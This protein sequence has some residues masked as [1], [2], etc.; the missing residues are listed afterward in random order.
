MPARPAFNTICDDYATRW[1][2]A[3]VGDRLRGD[4]EFVVTK[5]RKNKSR[6]E[7]MASR[8]GV[9][10]HVIGI[11]HAMEAGLSFEK[12]LH[13]GDPLSART[14]QV[15]RARPKTGNPPFTWEESAYDALTH[16]EQ[17]KGIIDW[18]PERIAY[19]LECYN[20]FGY[21]R[22]GLPSPYLWCGTN[23]YVAGKY[24]KDG[25]YDEHFVSK[26]AGGMALLKRLHELEPDLASH[27]PMR[28][29]PAAPPGAPASRETTDEH[30][31]RPPSPET[32]PDDVHTEQTP[33][34]ESEAP[35]KPLAKSRTIWGAIAAF[36]A[37]IASFFDGVVQSVKKGL[38]AG[39]PLHWVLL[40]IFVLAILLIVYARWDDH[41]K[42]GK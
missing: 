10:W 24:V 12:H 16:E 1:T 39:F 21:H 3:E 31:S 25:V 13:N 26:Q 23:Q 41:V 18:T 5:I 40:G 35:P 27:T 30:T 36:F 4:I 2:V 6:Y 33:R 34:T 11:I 42:K 8:T 37:G 19:I 29:P 7:A 15:P 14:V 22:K 32:H 9:P 20:G 17:L 38:P 28:T